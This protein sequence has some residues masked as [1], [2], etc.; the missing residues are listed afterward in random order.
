MSCAFQLLM[1]HIQRNA[2]VEL[3]F[4]PGQPKDNRTPVSFRIRKA[5]IKL[6]EP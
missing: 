5:M 2:I 6:A 3:G 4:S 1:Q